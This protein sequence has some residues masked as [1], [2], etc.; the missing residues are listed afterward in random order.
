[1]EI[2]INK[3]TLNAGMNKV[4]RA[5]SSKTVIPVLSGVKLSVA[6]EQLELIG[7]DSNIS[8]S[9]VVTEDLTIVSEGGVVLPAKEFSSIVKALPDGEVHIKVVK[10]GQVEIKSKRSKFNLNGTDVNQYPKVKNKESEEIFTLDAEK[11]VGAINKTIFSVAKMETRPILT[12]VNFGNRN[13][14]L[15]TVATDSH[16]LSRVVTDVE[17]DF[18]EEFTLPS[19]ALKEITG[20][21][22]SGEITVSS[23]KNNVSFEDEDTVVIARLMNGNYPETDRLIPSGGETTMKVDRS[24]FLASLERSRILAQNDKTVTFEISDENAGIFDTVKLEQT[25]PELGVSTEDIMVT[26]IDGEELTISFNADYAIEAL[27]SID[28]EEVVFT[29][30]GRMKPFVITDSD[31]PSVLQLILPVRRY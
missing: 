11:L 12:G 13:G 31:D 21:F 1:M 25:S 10:E 14:Y 26:E 7:S 15:T 23:S 27:K 20:I 24:S 19:S 8:I 18:E 30:N 5:I 17:V 6:N 2:K 9:T 16:R 28:G 4:I 3:G 22:K 29:F